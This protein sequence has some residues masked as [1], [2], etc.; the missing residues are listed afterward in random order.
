MT[1]AIATLIC[2]TVAG[3]SGYAIGHYGLSAIVTDVENL[4]NEVENLVSKQPAA[5]TTA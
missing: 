1:Y 4:K 3:L 5:T 2:M